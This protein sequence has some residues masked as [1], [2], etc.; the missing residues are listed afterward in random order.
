MV[1]AVLTLMSFAL[2]IGCGPGDDKRVTGTPE[3]DRLA[4]FNSWVSFPPDSRVLKR[5]DTADPP[6]QYLSVVMPIHVDDAVTLVDA[7]LVTAGF[8][9]NPN[10]N[11]Q[12]SQGLIARGYVRDKTSIIVLVSTHP[13]GTWV[14]LQLFPKDAAN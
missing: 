1:V 14:D 8:K 12:G 13:Q 6:S 5:V 7:G 3:G 11:A 10:F 4:P 9:T 2:I